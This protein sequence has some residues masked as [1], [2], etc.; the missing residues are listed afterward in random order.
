MFAKKYIKY[1]DLKA[2]KKVNT[3]LIKDKSPLLFKI[4]HQKNIKISE[5]FLN[6]RKSQINLSKIKSVLKNKM[7]NLETNSNNNINMNIEVSFKKLN[8]LNNPPKKSYICKN[9][10]ARNKLKIQKQN[11]DI[12]SSSRHR[13]NTTKKNISSKITKKSIFDK[14]RFAHKEKDRIIA[15]MI[16]S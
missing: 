6:Q 3:G 2:K 11:I 1:L 12:K 4:I 5:R 9:I 10:E 7:N 8:K 15:I 13:L 16:N 14:I